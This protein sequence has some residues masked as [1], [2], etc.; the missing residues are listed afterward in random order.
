MKFVN[1]ELA[2]DFASNIDDHSTTKPYKS[3]TVKSYIDEQITAAKN[4]S[5]H[6]FDNSTANISNNPTNAN[7]AIEGNASE[8]DNLG[9]SISALQ[10]KDT[11]H[12]SYIGDNTSA[13][14]IDQGDDSITGIP[15]PAAAFLGGA[16]NVKDLFTGVGNSFQTSYSS[17]GTI[18]G[19]ERG[20]GSSYRPPAGAGENGIT[21]SY[22]G[23]D[24]VLTA[25]TGGLSA[26]SSIIDNND[27]AGTYIL[28]K[29]GGGLPIFGNISEQ[30]GSGYGG[31]GSDNYFTGR[32]NAINQGGGG[33]MSS[34]LNNYEVFYKTM[35]DLYGVG[36]DG[37]MLIT[38]GR[39]SGGSSD[40]WR[41]FLVDVDPSTYTSSGQV[42]V[43][44]GADD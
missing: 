31:L 14:G 30:S 27:I 4:L 38:V 39:G 9:G 6:P 16:S 28:L 13:L 35:A 23:E 33:G 21:I 25:A 26:D 36:V 15:F 42:L 44:E 41:M 3:E 22:T 37:Y 11:T 12:D 5:N 29:D 18:M 7:S 40:D 19:V 8:I 34:D 20:E 2:I 24:M 43:I 1:D 32:T 10:T 17:L